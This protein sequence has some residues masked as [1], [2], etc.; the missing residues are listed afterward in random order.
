MTD[1]L[2]P[3]DFEESDVLLNQLFDEA[4]IGGK[5]SGGVALDPASAAVD[6]LRQTKVTFGN[7]TDNLIG[8]SEKAL[9]NSG[10]TL[11][12]IRQQQMQT[13]H[14]FYY[15]TI[16]VDMRPAS[17]AV[18]KALTCELD[19]GPKG[20]AEPIVQTIF[21]STKWRD[22][23][24][25]GGGMNLGLDGNLEWEVGV[26]AS[27]VANVTGL[28][29]DLKAGVANKNDMK[30]FIVLPDF[31]YDLGRFDIAA[32]GEGNSTCYWQIEDA[33]LQKT[34]SVKFGVVFKVPKGTESITLI[35]RAWADPSMNW[36]TGNLKP[37]LA[38]LGANL[39]GIF[40]QREA[41]S[42]K[43][44]RGA[45]EQWTLNLPK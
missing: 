21:P 8:L 10:I 28:P 2:I 39:Q 4:S 5:R 31:S 19:F 11:T 15:M 35:G 12:S 25:W 44:A 20:A 16:T 45:A 7:P 3:P 29:A 14:N 37:I 18:F 26:D 38:A 30:S 22:V 24:Q 42:Q 1:T 41:E 23:M 40:K 17:G 32:A 6:S 43:F 36:L 27:Q 9:H 34:I 33:D 13:S